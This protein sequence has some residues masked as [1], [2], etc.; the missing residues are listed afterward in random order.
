MGF[1]IPRAVE[2]S[3]DSRNNT[4]SAPKSRQSCPLSEGSAMQMGLDCIRFSGISSA[5]SLLGQPWR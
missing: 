4:G 5:K 2:R 3:I 1:A